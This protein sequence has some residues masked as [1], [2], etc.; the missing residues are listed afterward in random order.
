MRYFALATDYD[1]TIATHGEVDG[2]TVSALERLAAS[3]RR[4]VLVTGRQLEELERVFDRADLF[5]RVV[6]EN[7]AVLYVP[8][9]RELRVLAEAPPPELVDRLRARGVAPLSV[10]HVIVATWA[11]HHALVLET[12]RDLGLELVVEFNKGAVMVLPGGVTKRTGLAA[13]LEDM[14]LS[15]HNTV[16]VGDAEND[17]AF[18]A[19][20]ECAVS[21]AN[22]LPSVAQRSDWVTPSADG[23]GV[24]QLVDELLRDDLESLAPRLARHRLELGRTLD[25]RD[26]PVAIEPY[27][28]IVLVAGPS[29][30][31]KSTIAAAIVERFIECEYQL[32]VVD[33]EGD[34]EQGAPLAT[35]GSAESA[36]TVDEVERLLEQP[37]R[38]IAVTLLGVPMGDRA[39]WFAKL[40]ARVQE[41]RG[42]TGRPHWLIVDEAH[43]V[44][45]RERDVSTLALRK[46]VGQV[47]LITVHPEAVSP[48]VLGGVTLVLVTPT[49][50]SD[51]LRRVADVLGR[52]PPA[53]GA[54]VRTAASAAVAWR[55]GDARAIP[56]EVAPARRHA[57]R[58][59]RKYARGDVGEDKS[60]FF[61]G[62]DGA[63]RLR[64]QNLSLFTQIAGGVDDRTWEH[65]LR[66][67]DY[68]RW[69]RVAI[70]DPALADEVAVVE[71]LAGRISPAESRS[72]IKAAIAKRYTC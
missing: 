53:C 1:G 23:R 10:G 24:A 64:A 25:A 49:A 71:G 33:P 47:V 14:Q 11:P 30:S 5:E 54:P 32:C 41:A 17:H 42:R 52:P 21:V 6:A 57:L 13:A 27:G 35:V 31:G 63:L 4:L 66:A 70:K 28:E 68:S 43:H 18:L 37:R 40:L 20:C 19:A 39:L 50:A 9:T 7:G 2:P 69:L 61:R 45:P 65:H 48:E 51:S 60:F 55:T 44:L 34:H 8:A 38:S 29:G 56:F 58:H 46:P 15:L 26:A 12:I 3:G 16:G 59:K 36:P 72:R 62:P 67:G 22:A